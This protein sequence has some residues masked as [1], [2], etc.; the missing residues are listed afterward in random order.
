MATDPGIGA[1]SFRQLRRRVMRT[2]RA[3][4]GQPACD[5][6][7]VIGAHRLLHLPQ[8][9]ADFVGATILFD[10]DLADLFG[11]H[12][13]VQ[14]HPRWKQLFPVHA[15]RATLVPAIDPPA[16]PVVEDGFLDLDFNQLPFFLDDNDQFQTF[17]P[18]MEPGHVQREGLT[19][20]VRREPKAVCLFL[21][22]PKQGQ[23]MDQIQPVLACCDETDLCPGLAPH[24]FVDRIGAGEGLGGEALV[25]DHPRLL[26]DP[27]IVQSDA[28]P[29]VG[30]LVV[31]C[32]QRHPIRAPINHGRHLD[33]VLHQL[34]ARPQARE[35]RKRKGVQTIIQDLLHACRRQ[36]GHVG[37]HERPVGL[38]AYGRGFARMVVAHGHD[39]P[40]MGACAGHVRMAHGISGPVDAR[41][42][43]I[44]KPKDTIEAPFPP[45]LRLLRAPKGGCRKILVQPGL[46]PYVLRLQDGRRPSHLLI[47]RTKGRSPVARDV[48]GCI[49][50]HC[51]VPRL[52]HQH[53]AHQG[54]G[55][56]Q[57]NG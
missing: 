12:H 31:R 49:Q 39:D 46:K 8:P 18:L 10:Q 51:L 26:R 14:S 54:L 34:Q 30:H 47:N 27:V 56:V 4:I 20:L 35:P 43:P 37:V 6:W 21:V 13:R 45:K 17:R 5:L 44:P 3:E 9:G 41:T 50:A 1:R 25:V 42:F 36:D 15:P 22:N 55:A 7:R 48:A 16:P 32:D 57:K 23:G 38:M 28:K 33:R 2:A 11:N 53:E 40:A 52:L 24:P 19:D 29:P